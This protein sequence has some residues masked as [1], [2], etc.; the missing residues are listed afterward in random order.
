[1]QYFELVQR[2]IRAPGRALAPALCAIAMC[3]A[4]L[5]VTPEPSN[6]AGEGDDKIII[7]HR[8]PRGVDIVIDRLNF[9]SSNESSFGGNRNINATLKDKA[10]PGKNQHGESFGRSRGVRHRYKIRWKCTSEA[11]YNEFVTPYIT[12]KICHTRIIGCGSDDIK[13]STRA[14]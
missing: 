9:Q 8:H 2:G 10:R 7:Y 12:G 3:T 11:Q 4:A 14:P 1:M 6:A 5:M 13:G